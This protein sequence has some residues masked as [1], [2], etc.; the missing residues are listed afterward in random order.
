VQKTIAGMQAWSKDFMAAAPDRLVL[1]SPHTPRPFRGVSVFAS[2]SL[3]GDFSQF[4][5]PHA[6]YAFPNDVDW[7]QQLQQSHEADVH[8]LES[9]ALD[10]G[11]L[12]PLHFLFEAG[13]RGPTIVIGLPGFEVFDELSKLGRAIK[14]VS[15]GPERTALVASGDMSHCL[16]PGAPCGYDADGQV[17]DNQFVELLKSANYRDIYDFDPVLMDVAR[18]DVVGSCMVAWAAIDFSSQGHHFYEYEGPFGVGYSVM[19]FWEQGS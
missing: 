14:Q 13:W 19:K 5:A 4:G 18:Q 17:F 6:C 16:I 2:P 12:V 7:I 9:Q 11:A 1:I 3:T 8:L 10:H 15:N